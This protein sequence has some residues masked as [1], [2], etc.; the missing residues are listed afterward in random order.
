MQFTWRLRRMSVT[1][2]ARNSRASRTVQS[3]DSYIQ[4][5]SR[6]AVRSAAAAF[7]RLHSFVSIGRDICPF[8]PSPPS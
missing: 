2:A 8:P 5:K 3:I 1:C 7:A 6:F 4:G